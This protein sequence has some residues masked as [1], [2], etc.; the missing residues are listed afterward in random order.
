MTDPDTLPMTDLGYLP[1]IDLADLPPIDLGE[2][3]VIDAEEMQRLADEIAADL[4]RM[5][6]EGMFDLDP[7][8]V[9]GLDNLP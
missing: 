2:L 6:A 3:P 1:E 8:M 5:E 4:E 9:A 7:A